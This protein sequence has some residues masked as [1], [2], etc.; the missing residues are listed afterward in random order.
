M[1]KQTLKN[2]L[3]NTDNLGADEIAALKE[4]VASYP[5][6]QM[7]HMLYLKALHNQESY[8]FNGRLKATAAHT[9]NRTRIY[10]YIKGNINIEVRKLTEAPVYVQDDSLRSEDVM[11]PYNDSSQP[12]AKPLEPEPTLNTN[13]GSEKIEEPIPAP[14]NVEAKPP[15]VIDVRLNNLPRPQSKGSAQE[16]NDFNKLS[17]D[18]IKERVKRILAER[19]ANGNKSLHEP[20]HDVEEQKNI[21]AKIVETPEEQTKETMEVSSKE[22]VIEQ[23]FEPVEEKLQEEITA[24][25]KPA[26]QEQNFIEEKVIEPEAPKPVE[27]ALKTNVPAFELKVQGIQT[28]EEGV[29]QAEMFRRRAQEILEKSRQL[30]KQLEEDKV[31]ETSGNKETVLIQDKVQEEEPAQEMADAPQNTVEITPHKE[32]EQKE[33]LLAQ[34]VQESVVEEIEQT[35]PAAAEENTLDESTN[36]EII[37]EEP[38]ENT[39]EEVIE[40]S[41]SEEVAAA[42]IKP[43]LGEERIHFE[44]ESPVEDTKPEQIEITK[45]EEIQEKPE[46]PND[47]Q[48]FLNWLKTVNQTKNEP[49]KS[50][51]S[52]EKNEQKPKNE[53]EEKAAL[54]DQFIKTSA[55][56]KP[57]KSKVS[58]K[59]QEDLSMRFTDVSSDLMTETL[60]KVY[61]EQGHKGKAIQAYEILKLKYPEK[62]SFFAAQ[63]NKLKKE[64]KS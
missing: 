11:L 9:L 4:L 42:S 16:E 5:Y 18:Q 20:L 26:E 14:L 55:S 53:K 24:R 21:P 59:P 17:I 2:I 38:Q 61:A 29:S 58:E 19:E 41:P 48:G 8:H 1:D 50:T 31:L 34:Q 43:K 12:S 57:E 54:I 35:E 49:S 64:K 52:K 45:P 23:V 36:E 15:K 7:G 63:I 25:E 60:A 22:N 56:F 10:E 28:E 6:F 46:V 39:V 62:S 47:M 33:E 3:N 37:N 32:E 51:I 40:E 30:K 13:Q 27:K 44:V